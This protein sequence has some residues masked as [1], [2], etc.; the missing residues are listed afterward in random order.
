ML[1]SKDIGLFSSCL[2]I[3]EASYNVANRRKGLRLYESICQQSN[4]SKRHGSNKSG[5]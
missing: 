4:I 2:S 3:I 5:Y 1:I